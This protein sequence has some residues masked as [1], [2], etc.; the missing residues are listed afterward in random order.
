VIVIRVLAAGA[1]SGT[2]QREVNAGDPGGAIGGSEYA[3]DVAR[4]ARLTEVARDL[5]MESSIELALRFGLTKRGVSTVLVGFSTLDH[6][7][8]AIR[9]TERGPLPAG[10][11]QRVLEAAAGV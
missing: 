5:G 3:D 10:A 2:S 4:A 9:F 8:Q 1:A 6:L 11:V 7:Q